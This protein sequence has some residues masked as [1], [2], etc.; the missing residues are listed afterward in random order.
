M[1]TLCPARGKLWVLAGL[2]FTFL[3]GQP[4][5][6]QQ[7]AVNGLP[8]PSLL[9][10][11]PAGGKAGTTVEVTC[12]GQPLEEAEKLIFS[13]PAVKSEFV[14]EPPPP[15]D[16]KTKKPRPRRGMVLSAPTAVKFKVTIPA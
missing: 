11:S 14:P 2:A 5:Q 7:R 3:A 9:V 8:R 15:V 6:A 1:T 4:A 13:N 12:A 16:P 10:V